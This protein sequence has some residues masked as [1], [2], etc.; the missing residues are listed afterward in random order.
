MKKTMLSLMVVAAMGS[1]SA[2]AETGTGSVSFQWN[3]TVPEADSTVGAFH[4]VQAPGSKDFQDGMLMFEN[5][6]DGAKLVSADALAFVLYKDAVDDGGAYDPAVDVEQITTFNY[7][8][9]QFKVG[10]NAAPQVYTGEYFDITANGA[11][12][13]PNGTP[14][15]GTDAP[16]SLTVVANNT[17][18]KADR[19]IEALDTVQVQA[20][21]A[22]SGVAL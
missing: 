18:A 7:A 10:V 14:I 4:I 12:I 9:E 2:M 16:V 21:V 8:L 1:M 20:V 6:E 5:K 11:V 17:M 19:G 3:G 13:E 22:L 15:A